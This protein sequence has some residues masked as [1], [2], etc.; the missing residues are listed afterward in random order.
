MMCPDFF[1]TVS[2]PVDLK[3]HGTVSVAGVG[4]YGILCGSP[5]LITNGCLVTETREVAI[6][7]HTRTRHQHPPPLLPLYAHVTQTRG[8]I[9]TLYLYRL[10]LY[11]FCFGEPNPSGFADC[12]QLFKSFCTCCHFY[13]YNDNK[14]AHRTVLETMCVTLASV[15][16]T[17]ILF[18]PLR[19]ATLFGGVA[20]L[21]REGMERK[22][23]VYFFG[24]GGKRLPK[25]K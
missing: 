12:V 8:G 2:F 11:S 5:N 10:L 15:F 1:R 7:I 24:W 20:R 22:G 25:T 6:H 14:P 23:R 9:H 19:Q 13:E 3:R 18:L 21:V 17:N 16:G 4:L